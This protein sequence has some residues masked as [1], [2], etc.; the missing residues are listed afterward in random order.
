M[1]DRDR[2]IPLAHWV[3]KSALAFN[4]RNRVRLSRG[5]REKSHPRRFWRTGRARRPI[6]AQN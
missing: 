5:G 3:A 2:L 6:S 4:I 1:S